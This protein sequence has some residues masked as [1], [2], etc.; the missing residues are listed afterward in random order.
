MQLHACQGSNEV[1]CPASRGLTDICKAPINQSRTTNQ[2]ITYMC[3]YP[4]LCM[5][6]PAA[7]RHLV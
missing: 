6:S 3:A 4:K 1:P 5:F 7:P 2:P